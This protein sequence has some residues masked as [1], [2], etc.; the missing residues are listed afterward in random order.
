MLIEED[1]FPF[2]GKEKELIRE[3]NVAQAVAEETQ[4]ECNRGLNEEGNATRNK[5]DLRD[6]EE[7]QFMRKLP[8]GEELNN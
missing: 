3:Q 2:Q 7:D 6:S 8:I 5:A 4:E 1:R